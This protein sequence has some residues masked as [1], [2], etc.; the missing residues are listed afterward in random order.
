MEMVL[1]S[2]AYQYMIIAKSRPIPRVS[3]GAAQDRTVVSPA[4]QASAAKYASYAKGLAEMN[5]QVSNYIRASAIDAEM[6]AQAL[7]RVAS[8]KR[9]AQLQRHNAAWKA[10]LAEH[11]RWSAP[12]DEM[13]EL[14]RR[15]RLTPE[16]REELEAQYDA[17]LEGYEAAIER[18]KN[19]MGQEEFER[20]YQDT[21]GREDDE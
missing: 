15:R 10:F 3:V 4:L 20:R 2:L 18:A 9:K 8:D 11:R 14:R 6:R 17:G 5:R 7:Q 21:F 16:K 12:L 1:S 13:K 19:V